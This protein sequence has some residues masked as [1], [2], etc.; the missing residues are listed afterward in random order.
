M[1]TTGEVIDGR[2]VVGELLGRGGMAEVFGATDTA[3]DRAVAIKLLRSPEPGSDL[4]FRSELTVLRRLDHP[5]LVRLRGSGTHDGVPYLVLDLAAG[6]SLAAVL[7]SGPLGLDRTIAVGEQVA[8]ALAHAHRLG[9]VHR[10][11]KP[12]NVLFDSAGRRARLADFGIA[13]VDGSVGTTA[14]G[15]VVGSAPYLAPEQVA[16]D[17]AGPEVDVYAL[18]LVLIECVT[19]RRCY[20]GAGVEAAVARLHTSPAVPADLPDWLGDVLAA[21]TARHA[22]RRPPA[23]A[24]VEAL[25]SQSS[26]PVLAAT[27]PLALATTAPAAATDPTAVADPAGGR[28]IDAPAGDRPA[29]AATTRIDRTAYL[30]G[31]PVPAGVGPWAATLRRLGAP[32]AAG[33]LAV[34][35]LVAWMAATL[36][37]S[38]PGSSTDPSVTTTSTTATSTTTAPTAVTEGGG[39]PAAGGEAPPAPGAGNGR[40]NG[41]G[42]GNGNGGKDR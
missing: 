20:P 31:G 36:G 1:A 12:S 25:R 11:V 23:D 35:L 7:A 30:P 34:V 37:D 4:R 17:G 22:A 24:V 28:T 19:G 14:T 3:T 40:G 39:S 38:P 26:E 27:A 15:Q 8:D 32:V 42:R 18:G 5:G 9:V 29:P 16:G 33:V 6:P 10:D 41:H 21:M 2:Y 13:R